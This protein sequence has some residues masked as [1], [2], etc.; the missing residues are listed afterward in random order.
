MEVLLRAKKDSVFAK[1]RV[2][3]REPLKKL[4]SNRILRNCISFPIEDGTFPVILF[5]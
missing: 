2:E 1:Q 4:M 5:F 3:G